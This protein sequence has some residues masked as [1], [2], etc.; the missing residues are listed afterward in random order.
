MSLEEKQHLVES[1]AEL[2]IRFS[3]HLK[4]LIWKC[5]FIR[6]RAGES[7]ILSGIFQHGIKKLRIF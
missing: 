7:G 6:I 1:L 3:Q 2:E 5:V 4:E